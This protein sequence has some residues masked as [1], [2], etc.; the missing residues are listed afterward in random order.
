MKTCKN[1]GTK[2]QEHS[3]MPEKLWEC[4]YCGHYKLL[5]HDHVIEIWKF[6]TMDSYIMWKEWGYTGEKGNRPYYSHFFIYDIEQ[7][8]PLYDT[9]QWD[10]LFSEYYN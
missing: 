3:D 5:K 6:A 8:F 4:P 2:W 9:L 10:N 7:Y 1:C